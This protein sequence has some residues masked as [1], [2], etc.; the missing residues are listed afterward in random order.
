MKQMIARGLVEAGLR[1]LLQRGFRIAAKPRTGKLI[2]A[3]AARQP[4]DECAAA[5]QIDRPDDSFKAAGQDGSALSATGRFFPLAQEEQ[6]GKVEAFR[7][8]RQG[9]SADEARAEKA[10]FALWGPWQEG[11][12]G[13][14]DTAIPHRIAQELK[15]L[16][17]TPQV[18]QRAVD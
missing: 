11:D 18:R 9:S 10:Q 12:Q 5:V 4:T 17:A 16:V 14:A 3:H 2:V 7:E 1:Q 13:L 8:F 6:G 15:L